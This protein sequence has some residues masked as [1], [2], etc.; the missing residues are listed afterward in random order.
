MVLAS[1]WLHEGERGVTGIYRRPWT[2]VF[3]GLAVIAVSPLLF[4]Q[5]VAIRFVFAS[6]V[7]VMIGVGILCWVRNVAILTPTSVLFRPVVGRPLEI[8]LGGVK[9][10]S[11][12]ELPSGEAG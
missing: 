10:V 11:R 7:F 3:L 5:P 9:R 8:P 2:P 4:A 12:V 6:L 1:K